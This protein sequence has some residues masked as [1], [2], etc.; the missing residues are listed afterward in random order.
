MVVRPL[1]KFPAFYLPE[2]LLKY[3][4][5][6]STSPYSEPDK[7]ISAAVSATISHQN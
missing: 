1:K 6:L 2:G 4:Q 7:S 5:H 3:S